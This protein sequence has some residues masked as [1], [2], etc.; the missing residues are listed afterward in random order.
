M[1]DGLEEAK[2]KKYLKEHPDFFIDNEEVLAGLRIPHQEK[3]TISL[4]EKQLEMSRKKEQ[5]AQEKILRFFA[6]A[7]ENAAI[8]KK[9]QNFLKETILG[10]NQNTFFESLHSGTHSYLGCDYSLIILGRNELEISPSII[11]RN[12]N[13]LSKNI[14]EFFKSNLPNLGP[15]PKKLRQELLF[16]ETSKARSFAVVPIKDNRREVA[17]FNLGHE[18]PD[19][20]SDRKETFFLEFLADMFSIL[21]PKNIKT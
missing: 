18:N 15:L 12:K 6:N 21:I 11:V 20:F 19:F 17:L 3:G 5:E 14:L 2:V 1:R 10:D 8:F 13:S 9:S 4:I 7:K 16:Q